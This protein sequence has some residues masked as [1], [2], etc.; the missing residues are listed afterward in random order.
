MTSTAYLMSDCLD[1]R[2]RW[3]T[4]STIKSGKEIGWQNELGWGLAASG[5]TAVALGDVCV[6]VESGLDNRS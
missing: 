5:P 2:G 3:R 1:P 6:P 4:V